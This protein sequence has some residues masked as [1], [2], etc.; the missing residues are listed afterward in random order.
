MR[1]G[2]PLRPSRVHTI[3]NS[4]LCE[5][6]LVFH[7]SSSYWRDVAGYPRLRLIKLDTFLDM[8]KKIATGVALL[9]FAST[10]IAAAQSAP[11]LGMNLYA[12]PRIERGA[13]DALVA[14]ISLSAKDSNT[15]VQIPSLRINTSFA[16]GAMVSDITDCRVRNVNTLASA[17]NNGGNA[18]GIT[19]GET[20]IP[21]DSPY[22][23]TNGTTATLALTCDVASTAALGGTITFSATPSSQVANVQGSNTT[24]TVT[25]GTNTTGGTGPVSGTAQVVADVTPSTPG[26]PTV[27]GVP[28]TGSDAAQNLILLAAAGLVAL[29]GF[30]LARRIAISA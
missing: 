4:F 16:N 17:L 28:N 12:S 27:P 24:V 14:L 1:D 9:T 23:V 21:L 13:Q 2:A 10:G 19:S 22:V 6:S 8:K 25:T 26:V 5:G 20:T 15:A 11:A 18:V 7:L 30:V 3:F 29:G